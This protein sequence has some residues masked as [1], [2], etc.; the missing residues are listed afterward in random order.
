MNQTT[1]NK[2]PRQRG[3]TLIELMI[4]VVVIGILASIA[5][6]NYIS[7]QRRAQEGTVK[8]NMHT[9]QMV[10]EDYS[11]QNDGFYPTAATDA[12]PDGRRLSNLCPGGNYPRNPFTKLPSVVMFNSGPT[13]GNPGELAINPAN[14]T[15]YLLKGNGPLGDTLTLVLT[16]GQ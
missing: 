15:D 5:I 14:V 12:L 9:L 13:A 6:P 11:I 3:F 16:T 1:D 10:L 2:T 4:V 7:L 8:S